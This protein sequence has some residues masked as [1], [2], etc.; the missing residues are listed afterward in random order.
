MF[1]IISNIISAQTPLKIDAGKDTNYCLNLLTLNTKIEIGGSPTAS[2]GQAPYKYSWKLYSKTTK[3]KLSLLDDSAKNTLS[4]FNVTPYMSRLTN[5]YYIFKITV[6][7]NNLNIVSDSCQIGISF[8]ENLTS[9]YMVQF[10]KD[11]VTL[12]LSSSVGGI[13]PFTYNWS[14]KIGIVNPY[15]VSP[16]VLPR[17]DTIHQDFQDY[18]AEITDA[19]GCK[20]I[21]YGTRVYVVL[22]GI[23]ELRNSKISYANPV[24]SFGTMIL[25]QDLLG[26]LL[27]VFSS[28]GEIVYQ[29]KIDNV[30]IPIGSYIPSSGIYFYTVTTTNRGSING[31]FVKE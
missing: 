14:P 27:Q 16:K 11:S 13:P 2:G 3:I 26:S 25:T 31:R 7:D 4:N 29:T 15:L 12:L 9:G 19:I 6:T 24:S 23:D 21:D 5:D 22:T 20:N 30:S 10:I 1:F 18:Q 17:I 8:F 28:K